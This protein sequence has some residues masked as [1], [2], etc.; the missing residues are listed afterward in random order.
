MT[1]STL[2]R[3]HESFRDSR[4]G[5]LFPSTYPDRDWYKGNSLPAQELDWFDQIIDGQQSMS[6]RI[7]DKDTRFNKYQDVAGNV[8]HTV[9]IAD[10]ITVNVPYECFA[11]CM[12]TTP[13][14]ETSYEHH[15]AKEIVDE[16]GHITVLSEP[17]QGSE[18]VH[19][20]EALDRDLMVHLIHAACGQLSQAA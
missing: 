16:F 13:D 3:E 1:T 12:R 11:V 6:F 8:F 19:A 15:A 2:E 18:D 9:V 7:E 14:G 20:G 10:K 5:G 17:E 4:I